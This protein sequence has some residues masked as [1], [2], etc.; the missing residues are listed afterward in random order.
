MLRRDSEAKWRSSWLRASDWGIKLFWSLNNRDSP[1]MVGDQSSSSS[2]SLL[3]FGT[4]F[5]L[6]TINSPFSSTHISR[7]YHPYSVSPDRENNKK[8]TSIIRTP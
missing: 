4:F 1:R 3:N 6:L 7:R 2:F 5:N 8:V